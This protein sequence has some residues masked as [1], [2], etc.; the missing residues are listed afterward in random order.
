MIGEA[1]QKL[2]NKAVL[3]GVDLDAS[4]TRSDGYLR[5]A[6]ETSDDS[7]DVVG[8]HRF[9]HLACVH[10]RHAR[11]RPQFALVVGAAALTSGV[12]KRGDDSCAMR[13]T[14]SDDV[15]PTTGTTLSKG[16][17]LVRPVA[18]V[19]AGTL[20]HDEAAATACSSPV[21]RSMAG[22]QL[23]IN[24][25]EVGDVR[26]KH[27]P[28]VKNERRVGCT[29]REWRQQVHRRRRYSYVVGPP[30]RPQRYESSAY[31]KIG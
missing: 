25:A 2:A 31:A 4:A 10:F 24:V 19:H 21:V 27:D 17:A 7:G 18:V 8:F 26:T 16:S 6:T 30:M 22:G 5:G 15:G 28:V 1:A 13:T 23:S 12:I 9:G 29:E 20:D 3:T 11:R 14:G